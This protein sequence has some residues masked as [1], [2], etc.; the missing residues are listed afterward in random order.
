MDALGATESIEE[1]LW[2]AFDVVTPA[3]HFVSERIVDE[4][5][6]YERH[7]VPKEAVLRLI[8]Q[9]EVESFDERQRNFFAAV[10]KLVD[11]V[12]VGREGVG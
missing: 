8:D 12:G 1:I 4:I 7:E 9:M 10:R 2:R 5:S 11:Q 3:N 6:R